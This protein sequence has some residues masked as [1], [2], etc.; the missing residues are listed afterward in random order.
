MIIKGSNFSQEVCSHATALVDELQGTPTQLPDKKP[1][2][3][4]NA[5]VLAL[6]YSGAD[7]TVDSSM[8]SAL[9]RDS[10]AIAARDSKRR[11]TF[12]NA[13]MIDQS[14]RLALSKNAPM[15]V[16]FDFS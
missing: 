4:S 10:Q 16:H 12:W 7:V 6:I 14:E 1:M 15:A 11:V 5:E 13:A 2:S 9:Q 3:I 8:F